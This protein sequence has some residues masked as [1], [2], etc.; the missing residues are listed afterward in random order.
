MKVPMYLIMS[1]SYQCFVHSKTIV[2]CVFHNNVDYLGRTDKH[3]VIAKKY[4]IWFSVD[5]ESI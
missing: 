1:F 3:T 4:H 5:K 2:L